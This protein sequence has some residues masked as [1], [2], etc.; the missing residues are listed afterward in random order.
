MN[1]AWALVI[2]ASII[3]SN[4]AFAQDVSK[5]DS[6]DVGQNQLEITI[7]SEAGNSTVCADT[8]EGCYIPK[9]NIFA[10]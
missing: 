3:F 4:N 1:I 8:E 9:K 10:I 6:V 2:L 5:I 7:V